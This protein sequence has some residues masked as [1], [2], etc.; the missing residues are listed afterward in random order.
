MY[1]LRL[2]DKEPKFDHAREVEGE[3]ECAHTQYNAH[4]MD[5]N[6]V[7]WNPQV[8]ELSDSFAISYFSLEF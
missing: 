2:S 3:W 7:K 8:G 5:I 1:W 6:S 4:D